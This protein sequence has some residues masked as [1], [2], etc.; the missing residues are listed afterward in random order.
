MEGKSTGR[1]SL[2]FDIIRV[3][4]ARKLKNVSFK[5]HSSRFHMQ[6]TCSL[7]LAAGRQTHTVLNLTLANVG[8]P[9]VFAC[10]GIYT[11]PLRLATH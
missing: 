11:T 4:I 8:S 10:V 6:K 2:G 3:R 7:R 5:T 1:F 9:V